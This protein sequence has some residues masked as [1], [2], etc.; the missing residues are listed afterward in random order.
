MNTSFPPTARNHPSDWPRTN[1]HFKAHMS[2]LLPIQLPLSNLLLHQWESSS[3]RSPRTH[4]VVMWET[5]SIDI[6]RRGDIISRRALNSLRRSTQPVGWQHAHPTHHCTRGPSSRAHIPCFCV[7]A[8]LLRVPSN[9]FATF[10][11]VFFTFPTTPYK[12][13]QPF[14]CW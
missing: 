13:C 5:Q 12:Y 2:P 4:E 9:T 8:A 3:E 6:G 10:V 14:T 11:D 7:L 1:S